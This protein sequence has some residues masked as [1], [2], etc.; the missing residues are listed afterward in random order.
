MATATKTRKAAPS[1]K[2]AHAEIDWLAT[3]HEALNAPGSLGKTYNRFYN[4]SFLNQIRLMMQGLMEPVATYRVWQT[5]GRQVRKGSKAKA[6]LAPI[7]VNREAK[8]DNGIPVIG[9]DGKPVK[10]QVLIGFRDSFS[11]FGYS[12][13]DGDELPE[14]NIPD[15]DEA[16]ALE[17][18]NVKRVKFADTDGNTQGYSLESKGQR[19]LAINPVANHP[20]HVLMHELAHLVL[21]HCKD[22][23][24]G[25]PCDRGTFEFEAEAT[26]YLLLKE[27]EVDESAWDASE[28]R[29]Y[30]EHWLEQ[31]KGAPV[32]CP[33]AE[34]GDLVATDKHV[35]R[36][37][38][39][40]QKILVAGRP[41]AGKTA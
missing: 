14:V 33:D 22:M 29:A 17:A 27:L 3:L 18:L 1:K 37:F 11:V 12:D 20:T 7:M 10:R 6:V 4:Y 38:S 2:A 24:D 39:A 19:R 25:K 35:S 8:D 30:I 34:Q 40:V 16:T 36:I 21:G 9:P 23:S 41:A 28:S 31:A 32:E 26:A 5:L 15:W 13:T